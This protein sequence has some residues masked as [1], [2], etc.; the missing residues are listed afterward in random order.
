[1]IHVLLFGNWTIL[2]N[3][4]HFIV[5]PALDNV[6]EHSGKLVFVPDLYFMFALFRC[7]LIVYLDL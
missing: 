1:M 3:R 5:L 4:T 2:D 6:G 7:R